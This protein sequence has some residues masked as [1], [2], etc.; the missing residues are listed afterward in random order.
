M[1]STME[2]ALVRDQIVGLPHHRDPYK[3]QAQVEQ[4]LEY[5]STQ[6]GGATTQRC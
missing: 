6:L 1:P 5:S 4:V 2:V 3:T